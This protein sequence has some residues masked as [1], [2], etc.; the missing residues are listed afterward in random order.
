[1]INIDVSSSRSAVEISRR[2]IPSLVKLKTLGQFNTQVPQTWDKNTPLQLRPGLN[3][4]Q[5]AF[6]TSI[7][8]K[9]VLKA[10]TA[11]RC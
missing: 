7:V 2:K 11:L 8:Q 6:P 10:I 9:F 3:T 5:I 4:V 1:M